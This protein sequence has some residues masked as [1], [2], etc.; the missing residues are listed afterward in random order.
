MSPLSSHGTNRLKIPCLLSLLVDDLDA[1]GGVFT[2]WILFNI[3]AGIMMLPQGMPT[4]S[5]FPDGSLQGKNDF[6]AAP[7]EPSK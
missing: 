1:P 2:H 6:R 7:T 5:Q 3:P 4:Q